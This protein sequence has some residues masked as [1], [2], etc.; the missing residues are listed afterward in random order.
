MSPSVFSDCRVNT[1]RDPQTYLKTVTDPLRCLKVLKGAYSALRNKSPRHNKSPRSQPDVSRVGVASNR[2]LRGLGKHHC[3]IS[4]VG[5]TPM[6]HFAGWKTPMLHF[7]G[8]RKRQ[9]GHRLGLLLR[10]PMYF[11]FPERCLDE[12]STRPV[13]RVRKH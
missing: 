12:D 5:K 13:P 3:S 11:F 8:W 1:L 7:A 9:R 4:R 6:L 10:I 2:P